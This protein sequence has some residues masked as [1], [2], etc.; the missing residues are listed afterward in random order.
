MLH[1][2][3]SGITGSRWRSAGFGTAFQD[4]QN[5]PRNGV[6]TLIDH[7][8]EAIGE[9]VLQHQTGG[10]R[11]R[12][13]RNLSD[14]VEEIQTHPAGAS[15][16]IVSSGIPHAACMSV[17]HGC[18]AVYVTPFAQDSA[19][20]LRGAVPV[21]LARTSAISNFGRSCES[22]DAAASKASKIAFFIAPRLRVSWG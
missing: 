9:K 7:E 10:C 22:P 1:G 20:V 15:P 19:D 8:A 14:N 13:V 4:R 18:V 12:T 11:R 3:T 6:R 16:E 21:V 2:L 17:E 5:I